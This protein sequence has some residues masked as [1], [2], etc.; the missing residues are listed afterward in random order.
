MRHVFDREAVGLSGPRNGFFHGKINQYPK[1]PCV[2]GGISLCGVELTRI[3]MENPYHGWKIPYF[4]TKISMCK[5]D[6][7]IV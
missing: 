5:K 1:S 3:S 7:S 6:V 4:W 2:G